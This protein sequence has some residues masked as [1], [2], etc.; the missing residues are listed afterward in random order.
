MAVVYI[1]LQRFIYLW[2]ALPP[3]YHMANTFT[4]TSGKFSISAKHMSL[5]CGRKPMQA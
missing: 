2:S 1:V 4:Y 5:D 3:V